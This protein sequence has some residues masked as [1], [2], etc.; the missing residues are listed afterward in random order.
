MINQ[1]KELLTI[2]EISIE[3]T[4]DTFFHGSFYTKEP[5]QSKIEKCDQIMDSGKCNS[6]NIPSKRHNN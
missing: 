1:N 3:Q 5:I 6:E 2:S 4:Q